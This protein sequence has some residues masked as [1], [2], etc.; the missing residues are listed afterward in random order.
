M[1]TA[2]NLP[3]PSARA[4]RHSARLVEQLRAE[5]GRRGWLGFDEFMH[6][7]LY[8]PG[9]GYYQA[10]LPKFGPAGDFITADEFDQ[11][12]RPEVMVR[13]AE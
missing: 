5:I 10:G 11:I 12:V 13:P 6:A 3:P 8:A 1:L 7:A 9:L 2:A 4:R